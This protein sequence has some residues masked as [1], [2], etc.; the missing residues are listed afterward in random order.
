MNENV[1]I[2]K[3]MEL[4][5]RAERDKILSLEKKIYISN[6][7]PLILEIFKSFITHYGLFNREQK[8]DVLNQ[9]QVL[10]KYY[11]PLTIT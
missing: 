7:S 5:L 6:P 9:E 2:Y 11:Y 3:M 8:S 10:N 4:A 1:K